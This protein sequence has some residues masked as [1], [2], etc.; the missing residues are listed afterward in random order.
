M[1][2]LLEGIITRTDKALTEYLDNQK[3][4]YSRLEI[5]KGYAPIIV[6]LADAV[7]KV[8]AQE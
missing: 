7:E 1:K 2:K 3:E 4:D 5:V 6:A 8:K